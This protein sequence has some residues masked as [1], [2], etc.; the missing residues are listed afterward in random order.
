MLLRSYTRQPSSFLLGTAL[1]VPGQGCWWRW[2]QADPRAGAASDFQ[3]KPGDWAQKP[4]QNDVQHT[5][6]GVAGWG[7]T[8]GHGLHALG[9][10][11]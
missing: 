10:G 3:A 8:G 9:D 4:L 6:L 7:V 11:V 1:R 5:L 2:R